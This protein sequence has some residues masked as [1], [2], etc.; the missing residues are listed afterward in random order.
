MDSG[1]AAVLGTLIGA[2]TTPLSAWVR[3]HFKNPVTRKSN[4]LRRERL[5]KILLLPANRWRSIEYL[6]D[7]IGADEDK[8]KQLL[9]EIDARKALIK[10]SKNWALVARAPFP[11]DITQDDDE[12]SN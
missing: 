11:D 5:K 2:L 12:D 10:G 8:T 4:K 9:L 3:E 1:T 6:A 7:A